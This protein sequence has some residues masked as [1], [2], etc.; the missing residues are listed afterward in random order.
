MRIT[1]QGLGGVV[2]EIDVEDG[3]PRITSDLPTTEA[4]TLPQGE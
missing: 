3:D 4:P 2:Q 1:V